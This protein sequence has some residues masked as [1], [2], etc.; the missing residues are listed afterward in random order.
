MWY[1]IRITNERE[2]VMRI[3]TEEARGTSSER[4]SDD[5][6]AVNACGVEDISVHDHGSVRKKGRSDYH[7]LYVAKG[8]C[9]LRQDGA[10][11][12][13]PAGC[14]ILFRPG[15]PQEYFYR[16]CEHSVSHYIHF[17]GSGTAELLERY[18]LTGRRVF[19]MGV[20]TEYEELSRKMV[21]EFTLKK[22][23]YEDSCA[24]TLYAMLALIG[25]RAA[26]RSS[27][28]SRGAAKRIDDACVRICDNIASPPS[29]EELARECCLSLSRFT[30]LFAEVTG[31]SYGRFI[32]EVR[33]SRAEE[34][35]R[36]ADM[37]VREV[38]E[39]VGYPDQ[40]YFSRLFRSMTGRSP[41]EVRR[42]DG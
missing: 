23:F 35:L 14:I 3:E 6:L 24:A 41:S 20:S 10:E 42:E 15:E 28:V 11:S 18:G 17:T 33:M 29:A 34:L 7:I 12:L 1:H 4:V 19:D 26:L 39:A 40:N 2:P 31:R 36:S 16:A 22:R 30:H 27:G 37:S 9:H 25:R 5:F 8:I 13:I 38:G 32:R 21:K